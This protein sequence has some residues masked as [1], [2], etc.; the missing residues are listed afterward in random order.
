MFIQRPAPS[1][2]NPTDLPAVY[3][4]PESI[5]QADKKLDIARATVADIETKLLTALQGGRVE[6]EAPLRVNLRFA[7]EAVRHLE[8]FRNEMEY[9]R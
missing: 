7:R 1:E 9:G 3:V 4:R 2:E 8:F 6:M 5:E